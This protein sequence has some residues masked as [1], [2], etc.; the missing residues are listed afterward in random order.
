MNDS[1]L[2]QNVKVP[3][4]SFKSKSKRQM[5]PSPAAV[6]TQCIDFL[7]IIGLFTLLFLK[8]HTN[9]IFFFYLKCSVTLESVFRGFH[10]LSYSKDG[11]RCIVYHIFT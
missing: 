7:V 11:L 1:L 6:S 3:L 8:L 2:H 5:A 4:S 10:T 9:K